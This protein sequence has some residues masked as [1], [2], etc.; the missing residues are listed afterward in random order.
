MKIKEEEVRECNQCGL[1]VGEKWRSFQC[2]IHFSPWGGCDG[3]L[4]E[5]VD[6]DPKKRVAFSVNNVECS[7]CKNELSP[8][9][10]KWGMGMCGNCIQFNY[11]FNSYEEA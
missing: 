4:V 8:E 7:D 6:H 1:L 5:V 9:E 2:P 3:E 11:G 10:E